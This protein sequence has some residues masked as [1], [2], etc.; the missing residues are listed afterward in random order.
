MWALV[1]AA[2]RRLGIAYGPT[3]LDTLILSQNLL[4][5]LGKFKLDIVANALSLP[6]FNHH[7][8][9]DDAL[10]WWPDFPQAE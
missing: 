6:E 3:Y 7:R 2:C 8:A 9:A 10:T 4:P 1:S 5:Q